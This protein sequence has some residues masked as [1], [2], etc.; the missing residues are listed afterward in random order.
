MTAVVVCSKALRAWPYVS[1]ARQSGGGQRL[2]PHEQRQGIL[3]LQIGVMLAMM[4][5]IYKAS[6]IS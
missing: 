2:A 6:M 3:L 5:M 1:P 4:C